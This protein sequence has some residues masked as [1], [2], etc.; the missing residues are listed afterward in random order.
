MNECCPTCGRPWPAELLPVIARVG[1]W[2][3]VARVRLRIEQWNKSH[4]IQ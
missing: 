2:R 4:A 1:D 3:D